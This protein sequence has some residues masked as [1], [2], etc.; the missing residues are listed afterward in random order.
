MPKYLCLQRSLSG[1][2]AE[3][4]SPAQMQE[5]YAKFNDWRQ[6][7]Q[8]NLTDMGG[9]LGAGKLVTHEAEVDGPFVEAKEIIG[10][11]MIVSAD[12]LDAAIEVARQCPGVVRPGSGIEVIEIRGP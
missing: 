5:M 11:Y 9:K 8:N 12:T 7:Y 1:G 6:K 2:H 10:G 4:P 3:T